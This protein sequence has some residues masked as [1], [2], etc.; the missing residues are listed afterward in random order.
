L[1]P[2]LTTVRQD[3][4][5]LGAAAIERLLALLR[6]E[7]VDHLTIEPELIIRKSTAPPR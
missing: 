1:V 5:L 6:G 3:Y 2:A 7:G 4:A